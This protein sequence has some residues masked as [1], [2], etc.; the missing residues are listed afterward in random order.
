LFS[1]KNLL[2]RL[3]HILFSNSQEEGDEIEFYYSL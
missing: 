2:F 3:Y 1:F